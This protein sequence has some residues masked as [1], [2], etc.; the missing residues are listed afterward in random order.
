MKICSIP[1]RLLRPQLMLVA[2]F[3]LAPHFVA[4]QG[5]D[6][7]QIK[8]IKDTA[9][10][11]C[12]NIEVEKVKGGKTDL[13]L[14]GDVKANISGLLGKVIDG[15][16]SATGKITKQEF[17]GI[18]QEATAEALKSSQGC[19][20]RIFNKMFDKLGSLPSPLDRNYANMI[21][22]SEQLKDDVIYIQKAISEAPP[23]IYRVN[24]CQNSTATESTTAF[25]FKDDIVSIST[26]IRYD[27]TGC[28]GRPYDTHERRKT[29][30]AKISDINEMLD[31]Y[32]YQSQIKCLSD[33]CFNCT[34]K[35]RVRLVGDGSWTTNNVTDS[36]FAL[37]II[38]PGQ[39]SQNINFLLPFHRVMARI[40]SGGSDKYFCHL[41]KSAC[42]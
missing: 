36:E 35:D 26:Y 21:Y 13:E 39:K 9:A 25:Y 37:N 16:G 15:Q 38:F 11:I 6:P 3:L 5:L 32:K 42:N 27:G 12:N 30:K 33:E 28:N 17:D 10:E 7:T 22:K 20:E 24:Y 4:A 31:A 8:I 14:Q 29:C 1:G 34:I 19:R 2:A 23:S 41:H 18:T 40:I